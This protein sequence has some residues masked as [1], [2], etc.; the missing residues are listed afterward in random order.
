MICYWGSGTGDRIWRLGEGDLLLE[1]GDGGQDLV[2]DI[3]SVIGDLGTG[4][5]IGT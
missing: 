2:G 4:S 3:A 5:V 1:N